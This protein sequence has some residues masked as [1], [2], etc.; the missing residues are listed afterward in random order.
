MRILDAVILAAVQ[1]VTEFFPV[2]SSGHLVLVQRLL[3]ID[4]GQ[5]LTFD[6]FVHL[7]TVVSI[8]LVLRR[9]IVDVLRSLWRGVVHLRLRE[10]YRTSEP[11][12]VGLAMIVGSIPAGVVGILFR[13]Q[14]QAAFADPKLVSVGL[15]LTGLLLFLTRLAKPVP[16]KRVGLLSGCL[17]GLAQ[18]A[19]VI[20]GISRSGVTMS[21]ATY[22]RL[23]PERAARFSFLL[24]VPVIVGAAVLETPRL[25]EASSGLT[26]PSLI[27]AGV[28][29][30]VGTIAIRAVLRQLERGGFS[31]FALYCL[32]AGTAGILFL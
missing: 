16:G 28:S 31:V 9:D 32:A 13:R 12:R 20:P 7:G 27:G 19:A 15:V 8:V 4:S 5:A 2:S 24:A 26:L 10:E 11:A 21:T 14:V 23:S 25:L 30:V 6:V 29:A 1:G 22:L 17:I 18:A 3:G